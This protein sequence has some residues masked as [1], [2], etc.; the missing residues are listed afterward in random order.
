PSRTTNHSA[1][2][3][4]PAFGPRTLKSLCPDPSRRTPEEP[5]QAALA[6]GGPDPKPRFEPEALEQRS[7]CV[8]SVLPDEYP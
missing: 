1:A 5:L 2:A 7:P 3:P 8:S 4:F 6:R